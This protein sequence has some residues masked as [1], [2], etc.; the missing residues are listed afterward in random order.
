MHPATDIDEVHA[1][2][3]GEDMLTQGWRELD[4]YATLQMHPH[5]PR[6]LIAE[7]YWL[8]VARAHTSGAP[9]P[10][11]KHLNNAYEVLTD[12]ERRRQYDQELGVPPPPAPTRAPRRRGLMRRSPRPP[13]ETYYQLLRVDSGATQ[14]VVDLAHRMLARVHRTDGTDRLRWIDDAYA[15]LS[16][17]QRRAQYDQS[18]LPRRHEARAI[19]PIPALVIVPSPPSDPE[20]GVVTVP[21]PAIPTPPAPAEGAAP[22]EV[23]DAEATAEEATVAAPAGHPVTPSAQPPIEIAPQPDLTPLPEPDIAPEPPRPAETRLIFADPPPPPV[24]PMPEADESGRKLPRWLPRRR[25]TGTEPD[26]EELATRVAALGADAP[27]VDADSDEAAAEAVPGT[28]SGELL[29]TVGPLAG[30]RLPLNSKGVV[31][32]ADEHCDIVL[33]PG[34][35]DIRP[36][37]ARIGPIGEGFILHQVDPFAVTRVNGE[38]IGRQLVI[39]EA[40]DAIAIGDHAFV[41]NVTG[42]PA[43]GSSEAASA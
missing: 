13:R 6:D 24:T 30:F 15:T 39:L 34:G 7:A 23:A 4:A 12:D 21:A 16:N 31:F 17:P 19:V 37:H 3:V 11:V 43:A 35:G 1:A 27:P 40:G 28:M 29:F 14:E 41:F 25:D 2:T 38:A 5:A 33:P 26:E 32:G 20:V 22:G 18:L 9:E 36:R 10:Y 8:L 42:A